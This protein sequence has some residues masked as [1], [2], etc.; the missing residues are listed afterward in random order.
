MTS[1]EMSL[2]DIIAARP[3]TSRRPSQRGK[4]RAQI[5]GTAGVSPVTKAR[6]KAAVA[7]KTAA[8]P[9]Q[10]TAEKIIVSNLP[11]DV[12]ESQV[13]ELFQ[14]TVGPLREVTLHYDSAGR[15]K[16][17]ATVVFSK[18]GDG[19]KAHTQYNNR[20]IDGRR[21]MKIEIV[22]DPGKAPAPSLASRVAPAPA[23]KGAAT[24]VRT[25]STRGR[26][27]RRGRG[28]ARPPKAE[29]TP[30]TAAD[31]DAEMEDYTA[32]TTAPAAAA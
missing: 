3:K 22:M 7:A 25:P 1:M 30:K 19:N 14:T 8:A 23:A 9:A 20:L 18:K 17:V 26:G 11:S 5:L 24:A 28:G 27:A 2:D 15:S 31:L 12:N 16:G 29:R 32:A 13:K 10:T 21:P 6:A 4:G